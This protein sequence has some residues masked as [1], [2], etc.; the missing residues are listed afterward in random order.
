MGAEETVEEPPHEVIQA[1]KDRARQHRGGQNTWM[2]MAESNQQNA[3][4]A[5]DEAT[6][7]REKAEACEKWLDERVPGWRD[8]A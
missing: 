1:I 8:E 3:Q 7:H 6:M 2:R 4:E 5:F